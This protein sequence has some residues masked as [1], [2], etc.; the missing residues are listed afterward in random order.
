MKKN[1]LIVEDDTAFG[2]M[3]QKWFRRN[4]YEPA[5][6]S[7]VK[8]SQKLIGEQKFDLILSDLRLP[9]GDGI[10]LL[11]WLR[12]KKIMIPL[13]VMTSYGEVQSAVAAIKYG[14]E[15]Y[16]EKP[17]VPSVLK[18]KIE[19]VLQHKPIGKK[20]SREAV[21]DNTMIMG[22]SEA[23]VKMYDH[24]LKVAP[25][26]LSVL[27]LGES[28]TGKEYIA[29]MIHQNSERKNKPFL[30]VDCGSLSREL[31][32]SELFGHL[33][34]SFTSAFD[35]KT[36][37]FEQADGGTVFLDEVGNLSYEVQIQLL[38]TLQE[39]KIRR[40][41]AA[42]DIRVDVRILAATN[43]NLE[44]AIVE[45]RFR[46]DLYHRLNEFAVLVPPLR[47]RKEDI[48]LFAE[49]FLRQANKEL[50]KSITSVDK[51]AIRQLENNYWSGNLRELRNTIRRIVLFAPGPT[52]TVA[53]LPSFTPTQFS[54]LPDE[55][56]LHPVNEKAQIENAL[57]IARG[58][59][60]QAAKLLKIDRKTLY[61]KM[62][63]YQLKL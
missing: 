5:L 57:K 54:T 23:A 24:I 21:V 20:V 22:R 15:D 19:Q 58:N 46:E 30:A 33:K 28:G 35:T 59:K 56:A 60:S 14:A 41:G 63:Q 6:C 45:G 2:M 38:R 40:V 34:G 12:E 43:E 62:H 7:T 32:P 31:A 13:I 25:T 3:L 51:E 16:L 52:I 27:I 10:L 44:T 8:E 11:Q 29:R 47:E 39:Q 17:I 1:V 48:R 18:D 36:G 53:D 55:L 61:N 42:N 50:T 26:R 4:D 37:V 9:D 49:E